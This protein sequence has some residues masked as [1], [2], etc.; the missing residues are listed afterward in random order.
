MEKKLKILGMGAAQDAC[1]FVSKLNSFIYLAATPG[2]YIPLLKVLMTNVCCNDCA[3][4]INRAENK[5]IRAS[6]KPLEL[7]R[8]F[9]DLYERG[10]VK[11]LFLS[12]GNGIDPSLA[13]EDILKTAEILRKKYKFNGYIHLKVLPGS[14]LEYVRPA[15]E[16]ASRVSI[17]FEAPSQRHLSRISSKKDFYK[18]MQSTIEI[19]KYREKGLV[20]GG[21]TTQF[22]VGASGET[23][24]DIFELMKRLYRE[25]KLTRIYFEALRPLK[26]TPL[27]GHPP[28]PIWRQNRL[29]QLDFLFRYGF[30]DEELA[31]AF[32]ERG[33]LPK[34]RDPK[35][36]IALKQPHIFPVDIKSADYKT[37]LRVPGIGPKTARKIIENRKNG[38]RIDDLKKM[39]VN[40]RRALP[41][42][43]QGYQRRLFSI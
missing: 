16:L 38:I 18:I 24:R 36:T 11:G 6:F 2:G 37:L 32:D 30:L 12:S 9:M 29:Y 4:C 33:Y 10:L 27:E 39:G 21:Q 34:E 43:K 35:L 28:T 31:L 14:R 1:S 42:I 17:N 41:F 5:V 20:P 40:L 3:Y 7:S 13:M 8:L 26:G 25:I 23:D 22:V 19:K 15:C